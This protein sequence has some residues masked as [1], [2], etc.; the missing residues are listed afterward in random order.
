MVGA[1]GDR[2]V[3]LVVGVV[4]PRAEPVPSALRGAHRTLPLKPMDA[5]P[6]LPGSSAW[7]LDLFILQAGGGRDGYAVSRWND[8]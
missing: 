8:R 4:K 3:L 1:I 6:P 7:T 2:P 5:R